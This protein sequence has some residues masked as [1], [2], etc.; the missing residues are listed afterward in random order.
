MHRKMAE[1]LFIK[2]VGSCTVCGSLA[3]RLVPM[4]VKYLLNWFTILYLSV[5]LQQFPSEV[6]NL[7]LILVFCFWILKSLANTMPIDVNSYHV[8]RDSAKF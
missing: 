1:F 8:L 4:L 2:L 3:L 6:I 5:G 7:S